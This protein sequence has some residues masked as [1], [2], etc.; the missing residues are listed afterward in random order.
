V[1]NHKIMLYKYLKFG[2]LSYNSILNDREV[3]FSSARNLN[4]PFEGIPK[5]SFPSKQSLKRYLIKRGAKH[6]QL[7]FLISKGIEDLRSN[8]DK[9]RELEEDYSKLTG[10]LCFTPHSDS[11]LMWSHYA[12]SH[13]GICIGFEINLPFDSE[14]GYGYDVEYKDEYPEICMLQLNDQM[15]E[16][17][18]GT[19]NREQ[20]YDADDMATKRIFTK[21]KCW[22]YENEVRYVRTPYM[23]GVG[24]M[25]FPSEIIKEV[26]IGCEI[27]K[28]DESTVINSVR[29]NVPHAKLTKAYISKNE[30]KLEFKSII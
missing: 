27:E 10:V 13:R 7:K 19:K 30:Y 14:F 28:N 15:A 29:K 3:Y 18:N 23:E 2:S 21:S 6:K 17:V 9:L 11:L 5:Y 26:I 20:Y 8:F 22:S 12:D 4:D 25:S 24:L 16:V 1:E